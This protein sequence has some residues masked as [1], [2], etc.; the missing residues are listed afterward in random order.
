MPHLCT[1]KQLP[2]AIPRPPVLDTKGVTGI[3]LL[4]EVKKEIPQDVKDVESKIKEL[5]IKMEG[6][7]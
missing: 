6:G 4:Q 5:E 2:L 3:G 1:G 7:Y